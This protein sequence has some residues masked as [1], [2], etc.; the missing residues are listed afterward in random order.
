MSEDKKKQ[1]EKE[2][3]EKV[4]ALVD[5]EEEHPNWPIVCW[6]LIVFLSFVIAAISNDEV[7]VYS[8][9]LFIIL[10]FLV[11]L[12]LTML[13]KRAYKKWDE[14]QKLIQRQE[15]E[16]QRKIQQEE[17]RQDPRSFYENCKAAGCD[18]SFTPADLARMRMVAEKNRLPDSDAELM[19]RFSAGKRVVDEEER[20]KQEEIDREEQRKLLA[21][22]SS[23]ESRIAN[24]NLRY[25]RYGGRDKKIKICQ[26]KVDQLS[27]SASQ[28]DAEIAKSRQ[29]AAN[30]YRGLAQKEGDWALLGGVANGL[31][32]GAAGLAMAMDVQRQNVEIRSQ[33]AQLAQ[34]VAML[35]MAVEQN[36]RQQ[37]QYAR[38]IQLTWEDALKN[39]ENMLVEYLPQDQL[40]EA[41]H[42]ELI[43][44]VEVS[45]TG[46]VRMRVKVQPGDIMIYE[47]VPAIVDGFFR[48]DLHLEGEK[49]GEAVFGLWLDNG[50]RDYRYKKETELEGVCLKPTKAA[51][52]YDVT[53]SPIKL[54]GAEKK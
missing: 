47:S 22:L 27:K 24:E 54:W 11:S 14:Q 23:A 45:P 9:I 5:F 26:E 37:Q 28:Y 30:V 51:Q 44:N 3:M 36:Q 21:E 31:A 7:F 13:A 53:F 6:M 34:N 8:I 18:G 41:L 17:R 12:P 46:A 19:E 35:S 32:G 16:K 39:A 40:L 4:K 33:N 2:W 1:V 38:S 42:P 20:K 49:V 29:Q 50:A 10:A 25:M 43:G 48:A 52:S 15:E